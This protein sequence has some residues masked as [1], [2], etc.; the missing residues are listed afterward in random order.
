MSKVTIAVDPAKDVFEIAVA[1]PSGKIS[2]K[3]TLAAIG[4]RCA[5]D[6]S[7]PGHHR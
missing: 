5:N 7:R 2:E 6:P 4:S 1:K 3:R